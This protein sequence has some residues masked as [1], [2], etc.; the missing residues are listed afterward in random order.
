[1][2]PAVWRAAVAGPTAAQT[3][4]DFPPPA[5]PPRLVATRVAEAL[6]VDGRLDEATAMPK[7]VRPSALIAKVSYT[8][9]F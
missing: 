7:L 1:M 2:W 5:E 8:H 6:R 9:Q 3:E 4:A